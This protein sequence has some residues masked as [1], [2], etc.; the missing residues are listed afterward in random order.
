MRHLYVVLVQMSDELTSQ[1]ETKYFYFFFRLTL[2]I[3]FAFTINVMI[4]VCLLIWAIKIVP[5]FLK[6]LWFVCMK[7]IKRA[8][9]PR[10]DLEEISKY[11]TIY[12]E[13]KN[14]KLSNKHKK[15]V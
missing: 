14:N 4:I 13:Q 2:M 1:K 9:A 8:L 12:R 11:Q 5:M 3:V 10:W 7:R 6:W 15:E